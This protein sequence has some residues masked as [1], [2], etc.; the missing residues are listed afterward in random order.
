MIKEGVMVISHNLQPV[1]LNLKP[2]RFKSS[3]EWYYHSDS[4]PPVIA[5]YV[6]QLGN[7]SAEDSLDRGLSCWRA[8]VRSCLQPYPWL[9]SLIS[10]LSER[11]WLLAQ[12]RNANLQ[13]LQIEQKIR[14]N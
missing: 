8:N 14:F 12:D 7:F 2:E 5:V 9:M 11:P 10:L 6:A 1:Y 3:L 4:L 13:E